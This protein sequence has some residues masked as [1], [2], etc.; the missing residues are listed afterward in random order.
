M[1]ITLASKNGKSSNNSANVMTQKKLAE[2]ANVS[3]VTVYNC[4]YR[5]ELV[6]PATLKKIYAL[7]EQHDYHPDGIAR[8]MVRGR[9]NVIGIIV[10]NFEVAY[11]AKIVSAIERE[12]KS[13]GCHC[14]ICQHHDEPAQEIIEINMMREYR[15]DGIILRN[16]G[17]NIDNE[18]IKRLSN[19]GIPFV[20]MDGR[21]EGLDKHYVG[22][23]D[24]KGAFDAVEYLIGKKHSRIAC[25]GFHRSGDICQSDRYKGYA[26][27]LE[28]HKLA[29]DPVLAKQCRTEYGSGCEETL[30]IFKE[31]GDNPPT[32]FLTLNDHTALGVVS[33]LKKLG[34]KADV[35][36][37][38][39][40]LDQA[41]LPEKL[42]TVI[43]NTDILAKQVAEML[44]KQINKE[45]ADGPVLV[46]CSLSCCK[47]KN[48]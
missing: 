27:A 29:I 17:S 36:G 6:K 26:A 16:C 32:A 22:Y 19:A 20:L 33:A 11:Y 47:P 37:F 15:V 14:I 46:K 30:S 2:L 31:C 48:K 28:K 5:K 9:T 38:G 21:S 4:L 35:F 43:Q 12:I 40:Y 23:D 44:F 7:M 39:G 41:I 10:P 3:S 13:N 18:Q 25:V 42:P 1:S 34:A 24:Y 45:E 8:A